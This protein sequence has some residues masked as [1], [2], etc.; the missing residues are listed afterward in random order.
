LRHQTPCAELQKYQ[1]DQNLYVN[2]ERRT[3]EV[4]CCE[5]QWDP[6]AYHADGNGSQPKTRESWYIFSTSQ[7]L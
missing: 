6:N 3:F 7:I 4:D 1:N 2:C 5:V